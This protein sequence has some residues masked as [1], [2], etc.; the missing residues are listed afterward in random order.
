MV[1][2]IDMETLRE[3]VG[4]TPAEVAAHL[5]KDQNTIRNWEAGRTIPKLTPD[6]YLE[7]LRLYQCTPEELAAAGHNTRKNRERRKPGRKPKGEGGK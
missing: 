3:R 5:K 4:L 2:D 1:K 6:E 7:A